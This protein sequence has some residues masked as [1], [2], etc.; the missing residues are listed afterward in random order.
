[1]FQQVLESPV[2]TTLGIPA[3]LL[4]EEVPC[5]LA[6]LLFITKLSGREKVA[7]FFYFHFIDGETEAQSGCYERRQN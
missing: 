4:T 5:I 7:F 2:A 1:M 6:Y 3:I